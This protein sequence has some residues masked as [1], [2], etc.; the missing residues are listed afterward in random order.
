MNLETFK[1]RARR[2]LELPYGGHASVPESAARATQSSAQPAPSEPAAGR[3]EP[4]RQAP[5]DSP[6]EQDQDS[7]TPIDQS[8]KP[9]ASSDR[10]AS[11]MAHARSEQQRVSKTGDADRHV[12]PLNTASEDARTASVHALS[13]SPT[14]PTE[15]RSTRAAATDNPTGD[16]DFQHL[17]SLL[18][19]KGYE[20]QQDQ[21]DVVYQRTQAGINALRRD[22]DARLTDLTDYVEQLEQSILNALDNQQDSAAQATADGGLGADA[23]ERL[24]QSGVVLEEQ[25]ET[26]L[27]S[28]DTRLTGMLDKL[29]SDIDEHRQEDRAFLQQ[30]LQAVNDRTD[31]LLA[32]LGERF[33]ASLESIQSNLSTQLQQSPNPL[34]GAAPTDG[35]SEA[36]I[37][38]LRERLG[39]LIDERIAAFNSDQTSGLRQ[40]RDTLVA[41]TE[42]IKTELQTQSATQRKTLEAHRSELESQFNAAITTLNNSKVS[43]KEL[44]QLLSRLADRLQHL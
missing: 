33:E 20:S 5:A 36:T 17:R 44:S 42:A 43:H 30:E 27:G 6:P 26:R 8:A 39:E 12:D 1:A 7:M 34:L 4:T 18:L 24:T 14:A 38:G 32:G 23:A 40:L 13:S 22:M 19:G 2:K 37:N 29:R 10:F 3:P 9:Q 25:L 35:E 31:T 11:A 21:V 16:A 28:M 41:N 15:A